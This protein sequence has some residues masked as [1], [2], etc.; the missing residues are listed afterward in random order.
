VFE[1]VLNIFVA[2]KRELLRSSRARTAAS[3]VGVLDHP[4]F[5]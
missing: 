2:T 3:I 4:L 5:F 1:L